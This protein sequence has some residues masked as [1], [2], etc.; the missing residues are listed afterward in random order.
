[1]AKTTKDSIKI[2]SYHEDGT[3]ITI[4]AAARPL[5]M[6]VLHEVEALRTQYTDFAQLAAL[7]ASRA[8][9]GFD[10]TDETM[11]PFKQLIKMFEKGMTGEQAV[12]LLRK[13]MGE[14][15][16]KNSELSVELLRK[17][18]V[19]EQLKTSEKE[20]I[21]SD[22]HGDFWQNADLT[23]IREQAEDYFRRYQ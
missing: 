19:R 10:D 16:L 2:V 20:L 7:I 5:S 14:T 23:L 3:Q 12:A 15:A 18:M 21:D 22:I 13:D 17:L 1:M 8:E 4:E 6:K 11:K 9:A